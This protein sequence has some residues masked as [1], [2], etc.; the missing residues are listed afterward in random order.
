MRR[1]DPLLRD[2]SSLNKRAEGPPRCSALTSGRF[3]GRIGVFELSI[4][5]VLVLLVGAIAMAVLQADQG[6]AVP[7]NAPAGNPK[8]WA[9]ENAT[10]VAVQRNS[11]TF[12]TKPKCAASCKPVRRRLL[13]LKLDDRR[14]GRAR[15]VPEGAEKRRDAGAGAEGGEETR[16][17]DVDVC[18]R[19]GCERLEKRPAARLN[20]AVREATEMKGELSAVLGAVP[21]ATKL[22]LMVCCV[23]LAMAAIVL[24]LLWE[25]NVAHEVWQQAAINRRPELIDMKPDADG[26][27]RVR[28]MSGGKVPA[29]STQAPEGKKAR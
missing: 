22:G 3:A 2:A 12:A 9:C 10:C 19:L 13:V 1:D 28:L 14:A 20:A 29:Q 7:P 21:R 24:K 27:I 6:R 26:T 8:A 11:S 15:A 17:S 18:K 23:L 25:R 16:T 5:F 4:F